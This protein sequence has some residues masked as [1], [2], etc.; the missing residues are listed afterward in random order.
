[1]GDSSGINLTKLAD[2]VVV[3]PPAPVAPKFRIA[4][5]GEAV[6][7]GR[8]DAFQHFTDVK[9]ASGITGVSE[10]VLAG[11][12]PGQQVVVDAAN[13]KPG[14]NTF[15]TGEGGGVGVT[16]IGSDALP[17]QLEGVGVF[18]A[19]QQYVIE[20]SQET[21]VTN[22]VQ[23]REWNASRSMW[24]LPGDTTLKGTITVKK[25]R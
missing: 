20:F 10:E 2:G 8:G 5:P 23:M 14:V 6:N 17:G 19:K 9:G 3:G 22:G 12:K 16:K 25:V 24:Q 18:G 4:Q 13:F 11:L 7:I 21:V 15:G 1:M